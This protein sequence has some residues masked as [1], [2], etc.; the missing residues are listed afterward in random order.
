MIALQKTMESR[1]SL[2][3]LG[4][5][6]LSLAVC[7]AVAFV[8]SQQLFRWDPGEKAPRRAKLFAA[9]AIIPFLLLGAWEIYSGSLRAS[10]QANFQSMGR[11][12]MPQISPVEPSR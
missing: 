4:P 11:Q 8:I 9:S 1:T 6:I 7:A 3:H 2:F 10:A 12:A 5:E